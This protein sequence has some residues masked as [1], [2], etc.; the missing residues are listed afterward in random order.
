MNEV[1]TKDLK[2]MSSESSK[3]D[4]EEIIVV[5]VTEEENDGFCLKVLFKEFF[6]IPFTS[7]QNSLSSTPSPQLGP[8]KKTTGLLT[9]D[10]KEIRKTVS[11]KQY[12]EKERRKTVNYLFK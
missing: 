8:K 5:H 2:D 3:N 12:P 7:D 1:T 4:A 11:N 9:N 6:I 10:I